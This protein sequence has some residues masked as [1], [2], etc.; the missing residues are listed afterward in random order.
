MNTKFNLQKYCHLL[1]AFNKTVFHAISYWRNYNRLLMQELFSSTLYLNNIMIFVRLYPISLFPTA[2]VWFRIY[3]YFNIG[4]IMINSKFQNKC[5]N[6]I[7]ALI[8]KTEIIL[9][10]YMTRRDLSDSRSLLNSTWVYDWE[11]PLVRRVSTKVRYLSNLTIETAEALH[12]SQVLDWIRHGNI[13]IWIYNSLMIKQH[14]RL[15][16]TV[17]LSDAISQFY[18][19]AGWWI[20][21]G[22]K[23]LDKS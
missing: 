16:S 21:Q 2:N 13:I 22:N 19:S 3:F 5:I 23:S 12:V 6:I 17:P 10:Q 15:V 1:T 11:H 4:F 7:P 14:L 8:K 18:D 9:F 20:A